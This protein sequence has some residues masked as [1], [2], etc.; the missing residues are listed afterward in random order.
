MCTYQFLCAVESLNACFV[1]SLF[2][3]YD[4]VNS[5]VNDEHL[6]KMNPE[7]IPDVVRACALPR[8][9]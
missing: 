9:S 4:F 2:C 5:N 3:S 1:S 8:F 7:K 6:G